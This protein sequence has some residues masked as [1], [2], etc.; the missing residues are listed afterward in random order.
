MYALYT[1]LNDYDQPESVCAVFS[2]K[3]T[4]EQI[5]TLL[6]DEG[7]KHISKNRVEKLFDGNCIFDTISGEPEPSLY[8]EFW[9]EEIK[10]GEWL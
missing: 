3:P 1:Q 8:N 9:L 4:A 5:Y 10:E 7:F 6:F 2:N